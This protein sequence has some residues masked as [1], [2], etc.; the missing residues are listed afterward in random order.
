MNFELISKLIHI[1]KKHGLEIKL[2]EFLKMFDERERL[3]IA[4]FVRVENGYVKPERE[5]K[6]LM[7]FVF[8]DEYVEY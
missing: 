4:K 5:L 2:E 1:F 6:E 8:G 3:A 7:S